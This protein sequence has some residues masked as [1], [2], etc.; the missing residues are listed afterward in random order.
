MGKIL[1]VLMNKDNAAGLRRCLESLAKQSGECRICECFD[2]L[3]MDGYSKDNSREVVEEFRR[4]YPCVEFRYQTVKGGVGPARVEVVRYA[5]NKGYS[6]IVWGDSENIY[7]PLYMTSMR[8]CMDEDHE[9]LSGFTKVK[10]SSLWSRAFFW[11][12]AYHILF[13]FLRDKHAPGNNKLTKTEV[14]TKVIYPPSSRSDDFFFTILALK[15][16]IR[17]KHCPSAQ[18]Y[19]TMPSTFDEVKAWQRARVKGLIEGAL[20]VGLPMPPDLLPWSLFA[21]MPVAIIALIVIAL[22]A[23]PPHCYVGLGLLAG[24]IAGFGVMAF[25]L[26]RL[27]KKVYEAPKPLQGLLALWG[28]YLHAV[29]TLYYAVKYL[30]NFGKIKDR[31][32]GKLEGVLRRFGFSPKLARIKQ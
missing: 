30:L 17:F 32:V 9:V 10:H 18:V 23:P 3:V 20:M 19:V 8:K 26:E 11:Y 5:M 1:L 15:R 25:I 7:H 4:R 28:M 31:L 16:G 6:Y 22:L 27:A 2:V 24:I 12:H 29:F 14:F 21:L 13:S